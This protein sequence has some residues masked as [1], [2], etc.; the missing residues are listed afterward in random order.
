[1]QPQPKLNLSL[2]SIPTAAADTAE[3]NFL[4]YTAVT[5][6]TEIF[7]FIIIIIIIILAEAAEAGRKTGK[8]L[9]STLFAATVVTEDER[10]FNFGFVA[11]RPRFSR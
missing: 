10:R 6:I 5:I 4:N 7:Y 11:S 1:M 2:S 9:I 8:D 3:I